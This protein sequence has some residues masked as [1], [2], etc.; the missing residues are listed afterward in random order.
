MIGIRYVRFGAAVVILG[1]TQFLNSCSNDSQPDATSSE[2]ASTK[3]CSTFE[4]SNPYEEEAAT[5]PDLSGER[6]AIH[7][8]AIALRSSRGVKRSRP[9]KQPMTLA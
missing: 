5:M 1:V 4:P 3:N 6:M 8:V 7:A 2:A 9:R